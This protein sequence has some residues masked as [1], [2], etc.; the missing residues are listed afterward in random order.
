[1]STF[2]RITPPGA[3]GSVMRMIAGCGS[4]SFGAQ[5]QRKHGAGDPQGMPGGE[6]AARPVSPKTQASW[7]S[8]N[9]SMIGYAGEGLIRAWQGGFSPQATEDD[10]PGL[11][12]ATKPWRQLLLAKNR[13]NAP[14]SG[15]GFLPVPSSLAR[16]LRDSARRQ[17]SPCWWRR[18]W[19][20]AS[21]A[22]A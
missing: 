4:L 1:M 14:E 22:R 20:L 19:S 17:L 7:V 12:P 9:P 5:T 15:H 11:Q 2:A 21:A 6:S 16:A 18:G 10:V 13:K 3:A 8:H